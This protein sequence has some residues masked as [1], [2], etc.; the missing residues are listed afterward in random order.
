M[1]YY[2]NDRI[3]AAYMA[4]EFGVKFINDLDDDG[5]VEDHGFGKDKYYIHPDCYEIFKPQVGDLLRMDN[6]PR[7][8]YVTFIDDWD[9]EMFLADGEDYLEDI[10]EYHGYE[11]I[12]AIIQRQGKAFFEPMLIIEAAG[13]GKE[14]ARLK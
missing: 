13:D 1:R 9:G 2:Y 14:I 3:K 6:T 12:T 4:R 7:T 10:R 11:W 8:T 5:F